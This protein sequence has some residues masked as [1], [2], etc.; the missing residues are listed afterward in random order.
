MSQGKMLESFSEGEISIGGGWRER[1]GWDVGWRRERD[2]CIRCRE[3]RG[4]KREISNGQMRASLGC[5]R[6]LGQGGPRESMG[7]DSSRDL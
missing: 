6:D 4:E 7:G 2:R 3:S 5:D 1:T